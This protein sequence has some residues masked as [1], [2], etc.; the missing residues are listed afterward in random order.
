MR[1]GIELW[2][3]VFQSP[4]LEGQPEDHL[5]MTLMFSGAF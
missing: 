2:L 4:S 3:L 5:K 1:I